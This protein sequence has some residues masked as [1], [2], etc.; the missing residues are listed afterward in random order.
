MDIASVIGLGLGVFLLLFGTIQAGL[1]PLD[2]INIPSVFIT[3]GGAT[4]ATMISQ[5]WEGTLTV[6]KITQKVFQ[7]PKFDLPNL[8]ITLVSFSEK[9]RREGL[10]ALEDDINDLPEEFL[11]KG[12]QLV[13]DGTDPELVRNIMET[14]IDNVAKRH[15]NGRA[16]W[17][18]WG[19]L[20]P[21]FGMLGTLIGLI[22]MLNNLGAGDPSLIGSG[23]AAALITT[24]YGSLGSNL[25]AIPFVRKLTRRSEDELI[26]KQVMVEGTLSIQSG[27]NPRIVKEKLASFLAPVDR[28]SLKEEDN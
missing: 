1:S 14:E 11:R 20:A 22:A 3:F 21:G 28:V 8:I 26:V 9:A 25:I 24:L 7:T 19:G 4:A 23:M 16:W 17:D 5:P 15:L 2:L 27:D 6:G 18:A 13:V 12:I 10:L